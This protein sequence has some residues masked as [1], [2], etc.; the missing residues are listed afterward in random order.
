MAAKTDIP[1]SSAVASAPTVEK[2]TTV[3][4]SFWNERR[5]RIAKI[6][7]TVAVISI[8]TAALFFIPGAPLAFYGTILAGATLFKLGMS[9]FAAKLILEAA[10]IIVPTGVAALV[11][12]IGQKILRD[13][14]VAAEITSIVEKSFMNRE[15]ILISENYFRK[16]FNI[17]DGCLTKKINDEF[18][19]VINKVNFSDEEK[20]CIWV[21]I[22]MTTERFTPELLEN[23]IYPDLKLVADKVTYDIKKDDSGITLTTKKSFLIKEGKPAFFGLSQT[24]GTIDLQC[25]A[26]T[27]KVVTQIAKK[28]STVKTNEQYKVL[29]K[30]VVSMLGKKNAVQNH[31]E[32]LSS[33]QIYE[34]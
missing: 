5:V 18:P 25:V 15:E 29:N 30:L 24:Y 19:K 22:A 20:K 9:M 8:L 3:K 23:K 6:I 26:H 16:N 33:M 12:L 27:E 32:Q 14:E 21:M 11:Y 4:E 2:N 1:S 17:A 13:R 28:G 34:D 7:G 10:V 31:F